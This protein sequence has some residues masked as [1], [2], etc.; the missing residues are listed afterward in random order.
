MGGPG[1]QSAFG[2]KAGDLFTRITIVVATVWIFL[3]AAAVFF[4]KPK[5][6]VSKVGV[7]AASSQAVGGVDGL[8]GI[9]GDASGML[10]GTNGINNGA[11][12]PN[13]DLKDV[14]VKD[15]DVQAEISDLPPVSNT[16]AESTTPAVPDAVAPTV[17]DAGAKPESPE[18][19]LPATPDAAATPEGSTEPTTGQQ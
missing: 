14:D 6:I 17:P 18:P 9:E 7:G 11:S 15:L 3:C 10:P 19:A 5:K 2:T 13:L 8:D 4:L 1:G 16:P 12:L